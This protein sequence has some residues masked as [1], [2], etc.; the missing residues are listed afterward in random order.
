MSKKPFKI[1]FVGDLH[2]GHIAGL[3]PPAYQM[4]H[5]RNPRI[6][7]LQKEMWSEYRRILRDVGEVD[8][9][10]SNGDAVDGTGKKS[11][12]VECIT[13]DMEEQVCI[14]KRALEA[15]KTKNY[16]FTYGTAYHVSEGTDW[17]RQIAQWFDADIKN[18]AFIE[19]NGLVIS[20]KHHIGSSSVPYGRHTQTSKENT[21]NMFWS[22]VGQAPRANVF[23]RSHCHF[24][25]HCG[26][27]QYT[28]FTLPALQSAH[29]V[30]G[31]RRCSGIVDFG[32]LEMIIYPNGVFDWK[33]HIVRLNNIQQET[34]KY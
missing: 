30:F 25:Q 22:E 33:P 28:G 31:A 4:S 32:A 14:A 11:N 18:H 12:S 15:V 24:Y 3:T 1:L 27:A 13:V 7:A 17:E 26:N 23:I 29:T 6:S 10:V 21:W 5:E 8:L 16:L 34:I 19:K 2:C 20:V 9:C